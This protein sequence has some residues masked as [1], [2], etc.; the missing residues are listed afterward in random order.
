VRDLALAV[1]NHTLAVTNL[2]FMRHH[3]SFFFFFLFMQLHSTIHTC[4][5]S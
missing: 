2:P 1:S 5:A 4:E 3:E